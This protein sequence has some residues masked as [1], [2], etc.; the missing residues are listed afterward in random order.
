MSFRSIGRCDMLVDELEISGS[1]WRN[2]KKS[3]FDHVI[4]RRRSRKTGT[5]R[6]YFV[7]HCLLLVRHV[8]DRDGNHRDKRGPDPDD[9]DQPEARLVVDRVHHLGCFGRLRDPLVL[10]VAHAAPAATVVEVFLR[11]RRRVDALGVVAFGRVREASFQRYVYLVWKGYETR[12]LF[13]CG[14]CIWKSKVYSKRTA[15][16]TGV[17]FEEG[18][19]RYTPKHFYL[20]QAFGEAGKNST[21]SL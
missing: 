13:G 12:G 19:F 5:H 14:G 17:F 16:Y 1:T 9:K 20:I 10:P 11:V 8:H 15:S 4:A 21:L 3:T 6:W 18:T 7:K 2:K